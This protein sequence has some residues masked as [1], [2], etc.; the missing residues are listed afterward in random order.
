MRRFFYTIS[1]T[2]FFVISFNS[3]LIAQSPNSILNAVYNKM[4]KAKDYT[5]QLNIKV[6]LP[7]IKM[8]PVEAKV[9]F[10]QKDKFK[11]ESK[12]IAII[13]RQSFDQLTK[14]LSD[15]NAFTAVKSGF[16]NIGTTQMAIISVIPSS[17]T[18]ELILS[19]LW[20]D[21]KLNVVMKSQLTTKSNGTILTEYTYGSQ[22][23]YGLPDKMIFTVDVKKFKMPKSV[24]ADIN[25]T[26]KA[27]T[28]KEKKKGK[29]YIKLYNYQVNKGI[30]NAIF[31][32]K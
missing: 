29:I 28:T 23:A 1:I 20:I 12:N 31:K 22:I 13:P 25:N 19:K 6:D 2:G 27:D 9:Y 17:D 16:E 7:F 26:K 4:M 18:G 5:V 32:K 15:T 11:V 21:T 3:R 14:M 10:K 24:S 30:D 8:M